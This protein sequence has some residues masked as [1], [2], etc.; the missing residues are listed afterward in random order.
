AI[1]GADVALVHD[2]MGGAGCGWLK[3]FATATGALRIEETRGKPDSQ[4]YGVNP[5]PIPDNLVATS[6]LMEVPEGRVG[7][8]PLFAVATDGDADRLGVVLPGGAFFN[9]H[10]IFAVL[11]DH[12]ARGP[13]GRQQA[14]EA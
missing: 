4:F 1:R 7:S 5:E 2:P 14:T 8:G 6:E 13:A 9:S 3:G 11:L 12:L 10:Q